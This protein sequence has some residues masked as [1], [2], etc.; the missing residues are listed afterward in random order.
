MRTLSPEVQQQINA[1]AGCNGFD[2]AVA[3]MHYEDVVA[4]RD[5]LL[6]AV[7]AVHQNRDGQIVHR[8]SLERVASLVNEFAAE[9]A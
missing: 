2:A 3:V 9:G 6:M 4:Q 7:R 1:I 5:K 8:A